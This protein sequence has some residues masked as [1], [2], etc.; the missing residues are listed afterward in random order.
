[1]ARLVVAALLVLLVGCVLYISWPGRQAPAI[2]PGIPQAL[3]DD[4][5]ARITGL[6]YA[7]SFDV[8]AARILNPDRK[9]RFAFVR[10]SVSGNAAT[11]EALFNQFKDVA[12]RR[13]EAWVLEAMGYLHH[14][15]RAGQSRHLVV[16]AL[17]MVQE[18]RDTGDI[19]FPK[20]WA[21]ATLGGH[22]SQDTAADV[23]AY[24]DGLPV[25]YPER[26]RWVLLASADP[27]FRAAQVAR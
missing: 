12:N 22:R 9:A 16:P 4:R 27:L 26:L 13:R 18:I 1:M 10:P 7:I 5:A 20:R 14:P 19:F 24:L 11:R 23:R 8:P 21:D 6:T 25:D 17:Q 2:G 15:L 3:A